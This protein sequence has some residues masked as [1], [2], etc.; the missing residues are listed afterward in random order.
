MICVVD[1]FFLLDIVAQFN[2][3][4]YISQT[5]IETDRKKIALLYLKNWFMVD[6]LASVPFDLLL[7]MFGDSEEQSAHVV[8]LAKFGRLYKTTKLLRLI[9]LLKLAKDRDKMT[10]V[11]TE[12]VKIEKGLERLLLFVLALALVGHLVACIWVFQA[13]MLGETTKDTWIH[14]NDM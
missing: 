7:Y 12:N 8:L 5:E 1:F 2:S 6:L 3:A 11:L 10:A 14:S 4:F 9:K 13:K